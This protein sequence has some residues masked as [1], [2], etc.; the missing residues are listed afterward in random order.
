MK[1]IL[2][3]LALLQGC[4]PPKPEPIEE[5]TNI[6]CAIESMNCDKEYIEHI[7]SRKFPFAIKRVDKYTGQIKLNN[8]DTFDTIHPSLVQ[9]WKVGHEIAVRHYENSYWGLLLINLANQEQAQARRRY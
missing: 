9:N 5:K 7:D 8:G 6:E 3:I 2:C 1:K 4:S